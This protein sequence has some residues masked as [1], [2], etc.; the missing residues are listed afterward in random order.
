V[1]NAP[2]NPA[3]RLAWWIHLWAVLTVCVGVVALVSGAL[4]TSFGVGMADPIWPTYPWHLAL[5]NWQEPQPG[6]IVE[7]THRAADYTL[8][9]CIIV[10][11]VGLWLKTPQRRLRWLGVAALGCVIAQGLLGGFRVVLHARMGLDLAFLHGVFAEVVFALLASI[12]LFTSPRWL[13][14][15]DADTGIPAV[16][17]LQRWTL[18]LSSTIFVQIVFG[19]IL[20]HML[21][22][23]G[24]RGHLFFAFVTVAAVAWLVKLVVDLDGVKRQLVR[25][26]VALCLL[27]G[28]QLLLG[29]EAWLS[30]FSAG[31][32]PDLV[33]PTIGQGVMRSL[34]FLVGALVFSSSVVIALL[35]RQREVHVEQPAP[36]PQALLEAAS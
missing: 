15:G 12:A 25:F 11:A 17:Q 18:V 24:Q 5:I 31:V 27:V 2:S 3:C 34:H 1:T 19:G 21:S 4:V 28:L 26:T 20:R 30:R 36:A 32:L 9:L 22:P 33:R 14:A 8:G 10:L 7:H 16:Q 23:L 6:Y 13:A 29:I 35:A